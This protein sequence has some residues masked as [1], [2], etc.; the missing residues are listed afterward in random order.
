MG[1]LTA[2]GLAAVEACKKHANVP[3]KTLARMLHKQKPALY[4]TLE[5]AYLAVRRVRGNQGKSHRKESDRHGVTRP[6]G[7]A[8]FVSMPA[9]IVESWEPVPIDGPAR[10]LVLSDIHV[11]YHDAVALQAAVTFGRKQ[12]PTHVL[13]NGDG[14]DFYQLSR[15]DKDPTRR[16]AISELRDFAQLLVWLRQEFPK[17][18]AILKEGNHDERYSRWCFAALPALAGLP[19]LR[20]GAAVDAFIGESLGDDDPSMKPETYGWDYVTDQRPILCGKLPILHGHE[21]PKGMTSP[22]NMARGAY[23]R[24]AHTILVGHGHRSSSHVEPDMFEKEVACWSTGS[25][26]GLHPAYARVNKWNHGFAFVD[27][28]GDGT[29]GVENLRITDG[30]VRRS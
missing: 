4:P 11:P 12:K 19:Q 30:I 18:R 7:K 14:I 3:S 10:V 22:V 13:I 8:G 9:P 21:L 5:R 23:M 28:A 26:C 17:A 16:D 24:T 1:Q 27:V 20:L 15:F 25:L 2:V 6:N 29:F